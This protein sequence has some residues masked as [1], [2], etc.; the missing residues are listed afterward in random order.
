MLKNK[1]CYYVVKVAALMRFIISDGKYYINNA[2]LLGFLLY[3]A[4]QIPL[5]LTAIKPAFMW[6]WFGKKIKWV[7]IEV[8][9]SEEVKKKP[10]VWAFYP[11]EISSVSDATF[12]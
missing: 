11:R 12:Q 1:I 7:D 8:A 4:T 2:L 5:H 3:L 10:I 6:E 9:E